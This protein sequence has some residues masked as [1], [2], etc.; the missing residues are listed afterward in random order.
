MNWWTWTIYLKKDFSLTNAADTR[1]GAALADAV[2]ANASVKSFGAEEREEQRLRD[3][4]E[5]WREQGAEAL[6][7]VDQFLDLP[8]PDAVCVAS[9]LAGACRARMAG[10][11]RQP[12]RRGV[13]DHVVLPDVGLSAHFGRKH[14]HA[15]EGLRRYRR[16]GRVFDARPKTSSMRRTR[17][18][19]CRARARSRSRTSPS[20]T[21]A[22]PNRST[23]IS[24]WT[25]RPGETVALVGPT[26]SGKSTFV[27]LVQ[28]LYDVKAGASASTARTSHGEAG[29]LAARHRAGAAGPGAVPPLAAENIG[30]ARPDATME[31]IIA[32]R[33]SGRGRTTS[34]PSCRRATTPKS[35]SAA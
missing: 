23:A 28:R 16:R 35:A 5:D 15:A 1:I 13:C 33:P 22:K 7:Q 12:G 24:R 34:S 3:I 21:R 2:G 26:G 31:E 25:I 10:G 19:S 6:V 27:K 18:R 32:A 11:P 29:Q 14:P 8:E 9:G 4:A 17:R 30:Y 20:A